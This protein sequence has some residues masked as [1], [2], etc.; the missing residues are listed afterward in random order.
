MWKKMDMHS[1]KEKIWN[2]NMWKEE[3]KW[4]RNLKGII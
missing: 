2:T 1:E 3:M 4:K